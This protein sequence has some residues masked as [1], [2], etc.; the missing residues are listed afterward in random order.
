[1]CV[2]VC[3]YVLGVEEIGWMGG[4]VGMLSKY[5]WHLVLWTCE[6]WVDCVDDRQGDRT[7]HRVV[8]FIAD[9]QIEGEHR[10]ELERIELDQVCDQHSE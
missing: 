2:C 6:R 3:V 8:R 9:C 4:W 7:R 5:A 1:V 10:C